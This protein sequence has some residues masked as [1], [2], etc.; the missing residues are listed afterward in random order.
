M[1]LRYKY[2]KETEENYCKFD[3]V[4]GHNFQKNY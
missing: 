1:F 4:I 3:L 2:G